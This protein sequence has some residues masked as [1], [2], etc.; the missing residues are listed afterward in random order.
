MQAPLQTMLP[1]SVTGVLGVRDWPPGMAY[2]ARQAL[3][4]KLAAKYQGLFMISASSQL[5]C[6]I[7][8]RFGHGFIVCRMG[9]IP[10]V[11]RSAQLDG[12]KPILHERPALKVPLHLEL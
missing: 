10:S 8:I 2:P 1:L 4:N 7:G 6:R 12:L 3:V 5:M 11:A 9:S